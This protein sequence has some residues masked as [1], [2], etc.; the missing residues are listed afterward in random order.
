FTSWHLLAFP[1]PSRPFPVGT[2][3]R[4]MNHSVPSLFPDGTGSLPGKP[5]PSRP[6]G[7]P[8][9]TSRHFYLPALNW[10]CSGSPDALYAG[11]SELYSL[12]GY[13]RSLRS[14]LIEV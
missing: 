4:E 13:C 10:Y 11:T 8:S 3:G 12:V 6:G 7:K 5:V 9:P 14:R 1:V 2:T